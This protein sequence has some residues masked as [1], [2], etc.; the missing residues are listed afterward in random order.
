MLSNGLFVLYILAI[1]VAVVTLICCVICFFQ[2]YCCKKKYNTTRMVMKGKK[3]DKLI[4]VN[5][6][7][8]N[9]DK[10]HTVVP[11]EINNV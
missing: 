5:P 11:I 8:F 10:L 1:P 3:R 7:M 9:T 2:P 6:Y 4:I